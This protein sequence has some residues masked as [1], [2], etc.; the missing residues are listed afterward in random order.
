M[1]PAGFDRRAKRGFT[2]PFDGWLR[3]ILKPMM[4]DLL[5]DATTAARGFFR[6]GA[7]W[8]VR[9]A[10]LAGQAH[11]TRPWLLMMTELWAREVLDG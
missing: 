1:L 3:T 5:S 10:F 7:A 6:P 9:D 2:L 8:A 4:D 11:W